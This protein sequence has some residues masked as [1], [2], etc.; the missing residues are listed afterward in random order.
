MILPELAGGNRLELTYEIL[1]V[2]T[3]TMNLDIPLLRR[4]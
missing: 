2:A 3:F 4:I 1:L